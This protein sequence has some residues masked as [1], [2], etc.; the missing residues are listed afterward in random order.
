MAE[1][2]GRYTKTRKA[3]GELSVIS[4]PDAEEVVYTSGVYCSAVYN[5]TKNKAEPE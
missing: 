1:I 4:L 3:E 5:E 2:T